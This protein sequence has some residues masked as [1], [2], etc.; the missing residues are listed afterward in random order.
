M[1]ENHPEYECVWSVNDTRMRLD[2][3]GKKVKRGS[4]AYMM[5]MARAK[6]F[7][8]N[9]NFMDNHVKRHHQI[10]IQTMH[11]M[12]LK[13]LGLDVPG[14]FPTQASIDKFLRKCNRLDYLIVQGKK[15]EE[16][17]RSR[18]IASTTRSSRPG[19]RAMTSCSTITR[20]KASFV[21]RKSLV[22]IRQ[23]S[24]CSMR[25]Y[26]AHLEPLRS[27]ARSGQIA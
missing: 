8:N 4:L 19:I 5:K 20:L 13:A 6:F 22:S 23:R 25:P 2:G 12:P 18:A 15:T 7:L 21:S 1:D 11:G 16:I 14:D 27:Y 10:E 9:V 26:L 17:T 3:N 24:S